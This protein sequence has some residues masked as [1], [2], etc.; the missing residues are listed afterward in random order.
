MADFPAGSKLMPALAFC[1][2]PPWASPGFF[3][4]SLAQ[5]AKNRAGRFGQRHD[6]RQCGWRISMGRLAWHQDC[7]RK[8]GNISRTAQFHIL[9]EQHHQGVPMF[10]GLFQ[11]MHCCSC[12]G[13]PCWYSNARYRRS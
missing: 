13:L 12:S 2:R 9:L 8:L 1:Q 10:E 11:P 6:Q 7:S 3:S 4:D 5:Q